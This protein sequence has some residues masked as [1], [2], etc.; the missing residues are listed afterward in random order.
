MTER[1][2][3]AAEMALGLLEGEDLLAARGLMISDP[4]F[5]ALVAGWD[6][7]LAPLL[8][9]IDPQDPPADLWAR[10][11][12]AIDAAPAGGAADGN[13]IAL[14]RRLRRWQ[15]ATGLAA[16]A[17][18]LFAVQVLSPQF[19]PAPPA[20][21]AAPLVATFTLPSTDTRLGVTYLPDRGD[22]LV[23]A[24]GLAG[25]GV[26]DHELWLVPPEGKTISLGLVTPDRSTRV[27]LPD[28]LAARL[29][30]GAVLALTREPLGGSQG[31]KPG[32]IVATSK[33]S[34]T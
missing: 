28:D 33:F 16:L 7:K 2:F 29:R 25:D 15:W 27:H 11:S 19:A 18:S 14:K 12:Q 13:V 30:A 6:E 31:R 26:H 23:S 1:E 5:A 9:G 8:D 10:I 3:L 32:P 24:N 22:L 20:P 17:A 4:D 21:V 34:S